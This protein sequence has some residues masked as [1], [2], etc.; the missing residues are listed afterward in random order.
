MKTK[1]LITIWLKEIRANFL[2]LSV[3]LVG[4]GGAAAWHKGCF[5][6]ILFVLTVLGVMFAH[7][8]VNLFN[9]YSDWRTGI[10]AKTTRTRFNGGSGNLQKCLLKPEHVY[11]AAWMTLVIAFLI[12]LGLAWVSGWQILLLMAAGGASIIL[13]TDYIT[14]WMLGELTSGITLGSFV[15]I[16]AY[17][18]QTGSMTSDIIW[19]SI[20]PGILTMILLL[21]NEFPDVEADR[22]GGRKHMV[23]MLGE[24]RA[25][26]VYG[27][28]LVM[29]YSVLIVGT[30]MGKMPKTELISLLTIPL[31]VITAY[32]VVRYADDSGKMI[33]A[34]G[35]NVI[36]VLATDVL[37]ALGFVIG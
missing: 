12:G 35:M 4:I 6:I 8:S 2:V 27:L 29:V 10:D 19:A 28:L 1:K 5:N 31:A 15:V 11:R 24:K 30:I 7:I 18:V 3:V 16:G 14:R 34:L 17:Y 33:P 25:A 22:M 32:R 21:L 36:V 20:P 9:E 23:I 26:Y 13:Y 37:M